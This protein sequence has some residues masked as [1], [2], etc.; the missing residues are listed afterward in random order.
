MARYTGSVC[1]LCR[2]CNDKLMLKGSRCMTPKC[3]MDRKRKPQSTRGRRRRLSERGTQLIEKQKARYSYGV[4]ERQFRRFFAQAAQ[5]PGV[6]GDNLK[7]ILE[8]R[9]DNVVYRLG[10]GDSRS[11]TRQIVL[12]GHI[13]VNGKKVNVPSYMVRD[14][15][16]I[17]VREASLKNEYFKRLVEDIKSKALPAWLSLDRAKLVG[18][19]VTQPMLDDASIKFDGQSI[20]EYY[21]R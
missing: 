16:T 10:F 20:V 13:T 11:A 12:H 8:R 3:A 17:A 1:H 15:D 5:E 9:L 4:Y 18:Q 14:N 2:R 19:V 21:S 6:T 7:V